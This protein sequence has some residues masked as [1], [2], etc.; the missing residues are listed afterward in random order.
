[1]YS[2]TVELAF[3]LIKNG[4]IIRKAGILKRRDHFFNTLKF[5]DTVLTKKI[6]TG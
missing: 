1:M 5:E 4:G 2:N 6:V 3:Q